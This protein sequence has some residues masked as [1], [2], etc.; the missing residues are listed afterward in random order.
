[1]THA[2]R[3]LL[4]VLVLVC[5]A[6]I[7][8]ALAFAG[9]AGGAVLRGPQGVTRVDLSQ[10]GR[11]VV[12]GR[13]GSVVFDVSDGSLRCIS[14]ECPNQICVRA[15]ALSASKPIVCAPNGVSVVMERRTNRG[16]LDAVSR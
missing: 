7:P 3:I 12:P 9:S 4:A 1:M 10:D 8:A 13:S 14:S 6:C 16:E 15:G 2:D 5:V 11:Y